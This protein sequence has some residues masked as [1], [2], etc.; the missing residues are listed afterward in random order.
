M[1]TNDKV[2]FSICLCCCVYFV[3]LTNS[4]TWSIQHDWKSRNLGMLVFGFI[5]GAITLGAAMLFGGLAVFIL[6]NQEQL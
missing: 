1:N 3:V 5:V 4:L 2:A 6:F